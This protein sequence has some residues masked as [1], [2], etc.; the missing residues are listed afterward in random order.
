MY[1]V[2]Y[3]VHESI[4]EHIEQN[5]ACDRVNKL[6]DSTCTACRLSAIVKLCVHNTVYEQLFRETQQ[7]SLQIKSN[8]NKL[9]K[10][11]VRL[12]DYNS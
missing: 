12:N 9:L 7:R 5:R 4:S 8:K 3:T 11:K 10:K 2:K 1:S 6:K